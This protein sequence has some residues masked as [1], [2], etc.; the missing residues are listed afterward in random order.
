MKTIPV[1]LPKFE[2]RF[3]NQTKT[4]AYA[5]LRSPSGFLPISDYHSFFPARLTGK[6]V[7]P[8]PGG[9]HSSKVSR[10]RLIVVCL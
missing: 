9:R 10:I 8:I 2:N 3:F 5:N 7:K 4:I 1:F 6:I